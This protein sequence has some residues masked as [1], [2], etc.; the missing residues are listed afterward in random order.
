MNK[1]LKYLKIIPFVLKINP[2]INLMLQI[3]T[4]NN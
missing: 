2:L 4:C 3:L 1:I